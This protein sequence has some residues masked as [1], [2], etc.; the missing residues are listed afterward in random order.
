MPALHNDLVIPLPPQHTH[1][2]THKLSL[3][4]SI[5]ITAVVVDIGVFLSEGAPPLLEKEIVCAV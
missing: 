2:H 5:Y 3:S 4:L 1:T